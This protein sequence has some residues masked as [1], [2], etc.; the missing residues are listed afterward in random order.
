MDQ[1]TI[2]HQS[3]NFLKSPLYLSCPSYFIGLLSPSLIVTV[4]YSGLKINSCLPSTIE[5]PNLVSSLLQ[6]NPFPLCHLKTKAAWE[7]YMSV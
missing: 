7:K 4:L 2:S 6:Q 5:L 3:N 1:M